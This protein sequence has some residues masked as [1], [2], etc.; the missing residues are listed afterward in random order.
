MCC[1]FILFSRFTKIIGNKIFKIVSMFT[2]NLQQKKTKVMIC[3]SIPLNLFKEEN[4]T[5]NQ[6]RSCSVRGP[7]ELCKME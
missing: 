7:G 2:I 6:F 1:V 3:Y 4:N 5:L